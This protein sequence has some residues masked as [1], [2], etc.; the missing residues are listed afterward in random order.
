MATG[1]YFAALNVRLFLK[2]ATT[3]AS[4]PTSSTSM[5]EV[6]SLSDASLQTTSE[7]Q[8][9][10][11]YQTPFGYGNLLVTGKGWTM[12]LQLNLDVTSDGYKLLRR[13]DNNAPGGVTVQVWR[14][15][16]LVGTAN[17]DPQVEAGVAFVGQYQETL[18]RGGIAT[19]SFTLNGYGAPLTYQQGDGIAT[20]TLTNPGSGLSAGTGVALVPVSPTAGNLSGLGATA[21]ITVNGSGIIQTATIVNPGVSFR[22]GDTLTMSDPA[23]VGVG[24]TAPLFTVATV[25]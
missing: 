1:T 25:S 24:D 16:P 19:V 13:A 23:V 14:E 22:V 12:P 8:T 2:L 4:P 3:A 18:A 9:A 5:T 17:T 20:L 15:L 21:T 11:D 7:T 6:L 10:N